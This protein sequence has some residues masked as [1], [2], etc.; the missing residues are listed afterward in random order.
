MSRLLHHLGVRPYLASA[1]AT[2]IAAALLLPVPNAVTRALLGWNV[3]VWLYLVLLGWMMVRADHGR[4]QR[5][6]VA[7]AESAGTVLALVSL[8]SV[9]SLV[10]VV[11]EL[12]AA[13]LP[14]VPH[15]WPHVVLALATV[16]GSWALLPMVFA[17]T[18][19]SL[20]Y[21]A[22]GTGLRFPD[23]D[24]HFRP[25]YADFLYFSFTIAVA[26]QTSDVGVD[27]AAM[28]RVVLLQTLLSFAF[29]ATILAFSINIAASL[30]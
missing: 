7:Q 1:C 19:A 21:R 25:N 24:P 17:L 5:A 11:F 15:A 26:S 14:G 18:Y 4:V 9:A 3:F 13:K 27:T 10:G 30:F 22:H 16:V 2:G 23:D 12:S 20:Y 6:A 28:R 29:N 8:A